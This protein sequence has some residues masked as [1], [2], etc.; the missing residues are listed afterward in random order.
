MPSCLC[1]GQNPACARCGGSGSGRGGRMMMTTDSRGF[2][3]GIDRT[4]RKGKGKKAKKRAAMAPQVAQFPA[5]PKRALDKETISQ[6]RRLVPGL[7]TPL[8]VWAARCPVCLL[9]FHKDYLWLHLRRKHA[10]G[11]VAGVVGGLVHSVVPPKGAA[12]V[13]PTKASPDVQYSKRQGQRVKKR[14][15]N[16]GKRNIQMVQKKKRKK[17]ALSSEDMQRIFESKMSSA[18]RPGSSRRH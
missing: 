15:K 2:A 4:L 16:S 18:G 6:N 10:V 12:R 1:G 17:T 11:S 8:P 7:K 14:E 13:A 5:N 9:A 3:V